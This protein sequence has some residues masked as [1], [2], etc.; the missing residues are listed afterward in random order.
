MSLSVEL[1]R[2]LVAICGEDAVFDDPTHRRL[3]EADA[4]AFDAAPPVAVVLPRSTD[5][6]ARVVR[7]CRR[8]GLPFAARG[9]ATGLSGGCL[10]LGDGIQIGLA[11]MRS[12]L[13]VD[14]IGRVARVECGVVNLELSDELA[15]HGLHF[16][17]DP[18]S[19]IACTIGGNF[20]E[21][22]GGPHTLKYGVTSPH[23]LGARVVDPEGQVYEIGGPFAPG[24]GV[25]LLGLLCGSEGTLGVATEFWLRSSP[26]PP[27]VETFLLAFATPES[28]ASCVSACVRQGVVPAAM[29]YVDRV[30]LDAVE[31]V[32]RLGLPRR[33][34]AVLIIELDGEEDTVAR[35]S[36]QVERL[37]RRHEVL[38][39]RRAADAAERAALW[40][41]RKHAFGAIGRLAP[42]Y[43]TQDGVVPR[44]KVPEIVRAVGE[45]ARRWRL[46]V[47]CVLHAGD[48]NLHPAILYDRR[49]ADSV[50]RALGACAEILE[51]C[52]DLGGTP[53]GEHGIGL[54]KREYLPWLF[55]PGEL[56]LF[57]SIRRALDPRGSCNPDKILPMGGGCGESRIRVE[58]RG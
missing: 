29:E 22:A 40:R 41:A 35:E 11:R 49:D 9:A 50:E 27:A 58:S 47:G 57:H 56:E 17:P 37:A 12:I 20:A 6:V 52:I 23:V 7:L 39:L 32:H 54:E 53:T 18:S 55:G 24:P 5:E 4:Y 42:N 8:E 14:P 2:A 13:E 48:G 30:M 3:Y 33:A 38:E 36:G 34:A 21:N 31:A 44:A 51:L 10:V 28:A 16:A 26:R 45:I 19:Q 46:E 25:D 1:R 15:V 43:A